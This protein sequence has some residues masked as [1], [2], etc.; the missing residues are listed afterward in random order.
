MNRAQAIERLNQ[1]NDINDGEEQLQSLRKLGRSLKIDH[2]GPLP[3]TCEAKAEYISLVIARHLRTELAGAFLL[4][5]THPSKGYAKDAPS[6]PDCTGYTSEEVS[7]C[8]SD[9][10]TVL[11]WDGPRI[12]AYLSKFGTLEDKLEELWQSATLDTKEVK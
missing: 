2:R 8:V 9:V 6:W 3:P 1:A 11:D 5:F 10:L 7:A 12:Q 4:Y